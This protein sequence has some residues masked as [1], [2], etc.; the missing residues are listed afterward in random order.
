[1]GISP[2]WKIAPPFIGGAQETEGFLGAKPR[3][4]GRGA[5]KFTTAFHKKKKPCRKIDSGRAF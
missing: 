5:R 2:C 3:W 4:S 1:L